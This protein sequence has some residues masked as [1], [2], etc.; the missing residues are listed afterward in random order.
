M[1]NVTDAAFLN[2]LIANGVTTEE[3]SGC[4]CATKLG[5]RNA[6]QQL[7]PVESGNYLYPINLI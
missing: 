5:W 3:Y 2:F 7:V 1:A 6:F 4:D